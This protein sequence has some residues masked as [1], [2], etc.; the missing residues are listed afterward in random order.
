MKIKIYLTLSLLYILLFLNCKDEHQ[1]S[2]HSHQPATEEIKDFI[3][4]DVHNNACDFQ[5]LD[6]KKEVLVDGVLQLNPKP[7]KAMQDVNFQLDLKKSTI[8]F[9]DI[10]LDLTMPA[11]YMGDNKVSLKKSG[12]N[13]YA[14]KGVF[15]E[16][17]TPDRRWNIKVIFKGHHNEYFKNIQFDIIQ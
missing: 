3:V 2:H 4:C 11:M 13:Q 7:V 10:I 1:H 5:I 9:S 6:E 8:E 16:C 14:G 12:E 17:T 15:P